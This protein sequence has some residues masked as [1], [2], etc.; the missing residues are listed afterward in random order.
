MLRPHIFQFS[1][2]ILIVTILHRSKIYTYMY[3]THQ[4]NHMEICME[5]IYK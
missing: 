2:G 3:T 1:E 4:G 5:Y